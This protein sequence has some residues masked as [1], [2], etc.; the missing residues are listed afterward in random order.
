MNSEIVRFYSK[1]KT[2]IGSH[3]LD[4]LVYDLNYINA[5]KP[6]VITR[7]NTDKKK[8][9]RPLIKAF[10]D[11][12]MVL[13]IYDG[14]SDSSD[15]ETI[16]EIFSLYRERGF[17]AIIAL[18]Q[19]IVC[20]IAKAV[21]IAVSGSPNDLKTF[22]GK[23]KIPNH[24][25]P[26]VYIATGMGNGKETSKFAKFADVEYE[27]F[28]IMPDIAIVDPRIIQPVAIQNI[29]EQIIFVFSLLIEAYALNASNPILRSHA[30]VGIRLMM[31][32]PKKFMP[33]NNVGN[34]NIASLVHA[35]VISGYVLSN[36][37]TFITEK[38]GK[39]ISQYCDAS[40]NEIVFLLLPYVLTFMNSS[41]YG[42]MEK[43][44][45]AL[46]GREFYCATPLKQRFFHSIGIL[47]NLINRAFMLSNGR[48]PRSLKEVGF[49]FASFDKIAKICISTPSCTIEHQECRA[50]LK[51]AFEN[52]PVSFRYEK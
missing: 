32:N 6:L 37:D 18:G 10:N 41:G 40:I 1:T 39:I 3:A 38:L 33:Y 8:V 14:V 27:S 50:I 35:S 34:D 13:G 16:R 26:L 46:N 12:G 30:F 19:D 7:E 29:F 22:A 44:L 20:D 43:L 25:N 47:Q 28:F 21:N 4:H 48:F 11:S 36:M 9:L 15:R 2:G 52:E 5:Y 24:L 23:N 31:E 42:D 49:S 51:A 45:L 17:D